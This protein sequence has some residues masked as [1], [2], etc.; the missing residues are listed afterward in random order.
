[1]P[2]FLR[3]SSTEWLEH[4]DTPSWVVPDTIRLAKLLPA[5]GVDL[6]D[7]SSGGNSPQQRIPPVANDDDHHVRPNPYYQVDIA[8]QVREAVR[9]E[10]KKLLIGAVGMITKAEMARSLV[11][12]GERRSS[13]TVEVEVSEGATTRA[14]IVFVARQFLREPNWVL[15][16]AD[17]LGVEV[18]VANQY[19]RAPR[20]KTR[21]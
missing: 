19:M 21:L 6:L 14:D 4:L 12:E 10:G 5:L 13:G 2:L 8:G 9:Q 11:Q 16:V 18:K 3:I 1:M 20:R 15:K 17:E 7:V